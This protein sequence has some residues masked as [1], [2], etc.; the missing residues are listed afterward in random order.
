VV[1]IL[2]LLVDRFQA[3]KQ[4]QE[5]PEIRAAV[6]SITA[7]AMGLNLTAASVAIFVELFWVPGIMFQVCSHLQCPFSADLT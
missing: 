2:W 5:N 6:L 7:C 1:A 3:M 4:F